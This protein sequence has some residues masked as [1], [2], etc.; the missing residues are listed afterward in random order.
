MPSNETAITIDLKPIAGMGV[1]LEQYFGLWSVAGDQFVSLIQNTDWISLAAHVQDSRLRMAAG[2]GPSQ[3]QRSSLG[4][5]AIIDVQGTMTKQGNS[6][7]D[8]GSTVRLRQAVRSARLDPNVSAAIIRGDS[9]GG[10]VAGTADLAADVAEFAKVKPIYGFAEDLSASAMYWVLSQCTKIFANTNTALI[11]SIGTY[12]AIQDL[13]GAAA[14][15][16]VKVKLYKSGDMKG[17]GVP[18]TEITEAQD[19]MFQAM[20]DKTQTFFS[21]A[22]SRGRNIPI[23]KFTPSGM[24][25]GRV[26]LAPDAQALGL[27]DGIKSF[28]QVVAEISAASKA[29]KPQGASRAELN[30][31]AED[32]HPEPKAK[33][34]IMSDKENPATLAELKTAC[35]GAPSDFIVE[36]LEAKA[37]VVQALQANNDRLA[38]ALQNRDDELDKARKA[39]NPGGVPNIKEPTGKKAA[40]ETVADD[41]DFMEHVS[42]NLELNIKNGMDRS[43][44]RP[45]A[46][47][48][49][50]REHPDAHAQYVE[51]HNTK[52]A[53]A[54]NPRTRHRA[55]D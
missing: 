41:G 11:G 19:A 14:K 10:T 34:S 27:I 32:E 37:T 5:I 1:N 52:H 33:E 54:R 46:F 42:A 3:I 35:K 53:D 47:R 6:M 55:K 49:A 26:H 9:P 20:V 21:A 24:A 15:E 29:F 13:S 36:Q 4:S 8:A 17:A 48:K 18:G 16:G 45:E 38:A 25:D 31:V 39:Q 50:I 43:K 2:D 30:T 28:D 7:S 51:A 12:A 23:E 40:T 44:A 22:V